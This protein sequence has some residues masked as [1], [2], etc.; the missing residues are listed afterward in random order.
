MEQP[1]KPARTAAL[2]AVDCVDIYCLHLH[3]QRLNAEV[4]EEPSV[5]REELELICQ[6]LFE[7]HSCLGEVYRRLFLEIRVSPDCIRAYAEIAR[8]PDDLQNRERLRA[9][10]GVLR[11]LNQLLVRGLDLLE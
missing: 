4:L 3:R 9:L 1:G 6:R 7:D 8:G 2:E 11:E 5:E 10:L